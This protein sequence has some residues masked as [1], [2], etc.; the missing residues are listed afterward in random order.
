MLFEG[1]FQIS[2]M[3]T[4]ALLRVDWAEGSAVDESFK[5]RLSDD[6]E[7]ETLCARLIS[8]ARANEHVLCQTQVR[9]TDGIHLELLIT[10]D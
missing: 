4:S 10:C 8:L 2:R 9:P 3:N 7:R 1:L 5:R 6:D